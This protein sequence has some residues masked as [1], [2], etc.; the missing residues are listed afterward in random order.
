MATTDGNQDGNKIKESPHYV[1]LFLSAVTI[2]NIQIQNGGQFGHFCK[3]LLFLRSLK[4]FVISVKKFV[5]S[6]VVNRPCVRD[7]SRTSSTVRRDR[8]GA[9]IV[10]NRC[11]S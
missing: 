1:E 2:K 9:D 8:P 6:N 5:E 7:I 11:P 3:T 10:Q 4:Y